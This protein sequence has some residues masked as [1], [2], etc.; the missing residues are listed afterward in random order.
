MH[1]KV[2]VVFFFNLKQKFCYFKMDDM[3]DVGLR[4]NR[5]MAGTVQPGGMLAAMRSA[6]CGVCWRGKGTHGVDIKMSRSSVDDGMGCSR[7][8]ANADTRIEP[9]VVHAQASVEL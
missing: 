7:C 3:D 1:I 8:G 9:D 4:I 2:G 6:R 5:V